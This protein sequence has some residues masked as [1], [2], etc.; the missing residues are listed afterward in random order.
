VLFR[1]RFDDARY[2]DR[3]YQGGG[4]PGTIY[5]LTELGTELNATTQQPI[6]ACTGWTVESFASVDATNAVLRAVIDPDASGATAV[7]LVQD[8]DYNNLVEVRFNQ[9]FAPYV[10]LRSIDDGVLT[11]LADT[12]AQPYTGATAVRIAKLDAAYYLFVNNQLIG[13]VNND[14]LGDTALRPYLGETS[15]VADAGGVDSNYDVLEVLL[16][17]DADA[18]PDLNEDI[19]F[20]GTVDNGESDA[21]NY[22][23]DSDLVLDGFDNCVL[24]ANANQSDVD[25]DG[26]GDACDPDF[27][28]LSLTVAYPPPVG[29]M[30]DVY[31][32]DGLSASGGQPPYSFSVIAGGPLTWSLTIQAAP[33]DGSI[34]TIWGTPVSPTSG[35]QSLTIQV[36]DANFDTANVDMQMQILYSSGY[37]CGDGCHSASGF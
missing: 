12:T 10:E 5:V 34:G 18:L 4:D 3:W 1:D 19:N 22:D 31:Y 35:S 16:D 29:A 6:S 37:T 7:G 36:T 21:A 25:G 24:I 30:F 33:W 28:A 11:T 23:T 20:N 13:N 26:I 2:I 15:C 8:K 27:P 9:D 32:W 17:S 14:G